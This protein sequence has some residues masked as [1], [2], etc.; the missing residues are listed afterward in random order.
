M[1]SAAVVLLLSILP[2]L[3]VA[4]KFEECEDIKLKTEEDFIKTEP[5]VLECAN[6][7]LDCKMV[8]PG[9]SRKN[10]V[11]FVVRWAVGAP[12]TFV[13]EEWV[14]KLMKKEDGFIFVH[15]AA[16]VKFKLENK[17]ISEED[18]QYGTAVLIYEYIKNPKFLVEKK[19]YIKKF[20]AAGDAGTLKTL[21]NS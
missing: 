4:Q 8:D 16:I 20:V 15:L 21:I 7:V 2:V 3:S 1:K 6:Y 13:I 11:A 9:E 10:A 18:L 14:Y 17:D 12:Y 5:L 19:G